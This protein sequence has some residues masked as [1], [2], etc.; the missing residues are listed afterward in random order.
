MTEHKL[1]ARRYS[2]GFTCIKA[3]NPQNNSMSRCY[4]EPMLHMGHREARLHSWLCAEPV[5]KAGQPSPKP[6]PGVST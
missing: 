3:F 2:Q 4:Y 6:G 5:S 1:H